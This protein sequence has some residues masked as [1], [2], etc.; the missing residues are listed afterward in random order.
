M[1]LLL[2]SFI[3][4]YKYAI[5]V[6]AVLIEGPVVS[7]LTGVFVH[8]GY[9]QLIPAYLSLVAGELIGDVMWYVIGYYYGERFALRYGRFFSLT[10]EHIAATKRLFNRH[11]ERILFI[12]KL[13]NGLGL[14]IPIL[15]TAALSRVPFGRY[16]LINGLGQA[17]WSAFLIYIGMSFG[18]QISQVQSIFGVFATIGLYGI[19]LA[20]I[21]GTGRA[22]SRSMT[23]STSDKTL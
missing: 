23:K 12:S 16:M 7:L 2:S 9:L 5:I 8:L 18:S 4:T 14:G 15:F 22:I 19:L 21:I 17:V 3:L 13:V 10:P 20:V 6:P 1:I 11:H